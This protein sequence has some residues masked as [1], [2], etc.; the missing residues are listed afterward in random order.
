MIILTDEQQVALAVE[1]K[2]GKGNAARVDGT[3]V[4]RSSDETIVT[5]T[6]AEDGMTATAVTVGPLGTVQVSVEADADLG[7]G[8]RLITGVLDIEVRAAE[9][10]QAIVVAGAPETEP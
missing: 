4:W 8:T 1:F 10:V 6:P 9:A 2:T 5:L 7:D 3:P